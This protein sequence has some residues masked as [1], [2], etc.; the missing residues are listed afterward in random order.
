MCVCVCVCIRT[1]VQKNY[2][3]R[4]RSLAWRAGY[5]WIN[6]RWVS[7]YTEEVGVPV[8]A[9]Q[10]KD[11]TSIHEEVGSIPGLAQRVK[12]PELLEAAA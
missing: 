4:P 1:C 6:V 10:I 2:V 8:V 9:Q 12:D 3:N 5:E 7:H 11:L